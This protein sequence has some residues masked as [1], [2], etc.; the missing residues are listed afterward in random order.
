M[1]AMKTN[2]RFSGVLERAT[3]IRED[4]GRSRPSRQSNGGAVTPHSHR[5]SLEHST[6]AHACHEGSPCIA[7][8]STP[9]A[10]AAG[11]IGPRSR[12]VAPR[13]A[14]G[15]RCFLRNGSMRSIGIGNTVVE[16]FSVAISAR[17]CR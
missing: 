14:Y 15:A 7:H 8:Q 11:R 16:F 6:R 4:Q 17:V 3:V 9:R 10:M 1:A 2:A 13:S 5:R 12:S